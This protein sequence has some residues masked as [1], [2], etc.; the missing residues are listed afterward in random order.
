MKNPYINIKLYHQTIIKLILQLCNKKKK[1]AR[2][3]TEH[4]VCMQNQT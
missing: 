4:F 3:F 1:E 2:T